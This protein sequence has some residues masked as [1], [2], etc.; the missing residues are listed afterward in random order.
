MP[1]APPA[2]RFKLALAAALALVGDFLLFEREPGLNLVIFA[3]VWLAA[4]LTMDPAVRHDGL[5]LKAF[6]LAA[7]LALVQVDRPSLVGGVLFGTALGVAVL[8]PRAPAGEDAWRWTQRMVVAGLRAVVAPWRDLRTALRARRG[9]VRFAVMLT[10]AVLPVAGGL[11]FLWLFA[12]A[13]P[14]ISDAIGHLRLPAPD[15]ARIVFWMAVAAAVWTTLRPPGWVR[16]D[17]LPRLRRLAGQNAGL[18]IAT[19]ASV[20]LS[21]ALFNAL[22]AVQN[23]LDLVF[24]WSG[25]PLPDGVTFADYAHRGAYALIATALLAGLFV[26]VFLRPGSPTAESDPVRWLVVAWILQNVFLVASTALRTLDYVDAYALTRLR[27]AAL[28]WMGLVALGLVLI[29]WRLLR[30]KSGSWLINANALAAGAVLLACSVVDLG[31]FAAAW[32]V[33]HAREVG[34]RGVELDLCYLR[35]LKGAGLVSLAELEQRPLTPDVRDRV[36]WTRRELRREVYAAQSDP[37]SW[38][39]RDA[40]RLARDASLPGATPLEAGRRN[41]NGRPTPLTTAPKP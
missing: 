26:L 22:F 40:R 35:E 8:A 17:K 32:N 31:A 16:K 25:A 29:L 23:G 13:N 20:A 15:V 2:F 27:I 34:G 10:A 9:P 4:V 21:L 28:L 18:P 14:L 7:V 36:A 37:L 6:G 12:V 19:P 5:A 3:V 24:L 30:G 33:R 11:V 38:R 41:C 1:I 39:W